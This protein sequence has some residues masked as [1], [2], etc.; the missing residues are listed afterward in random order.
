MAVKSAIEVLKID[1]PKI[2][3]YLEQW[4]RDQLKER[5][6]TKLAV[7]VSG[8]VDSAVVVTLAAR[9]VGPEN[10]TG[11]V[12][13]YDNVDPESIQDAESMIR[14]LRISR[15]F[16]DIAPMVDPYFKTNPTDDR[17][18]KGNKMARERMSVLYDI[19]REATALVIG[20]SN[21]SEICM[22]YGT[23]YG[24]LACAFNPIGNLYKTQ[25]R[26]LAEYLGV[27]RQIIDKIPTAGLWP[28]Q[29]DE[30]ELGITYRELDI[31]LH[32]M[33]DEKY[34]NQKLK[35]MGYQESIINMVKERIA[36]NIFKGRLPA[37]API[38][39]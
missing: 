6:Y 8:G 1:A 10:V 27:E 21:R 17:V 7:G 39:K 28:G 3:G 4:I 5:G 19:S 30:G 23:L 24:D 9:A 14:K 11:V 36:K 26:Q 25:V 31:L 34:S 38:P 16:V 22:G 12:L 13:P 20:T 32:F 18:R 37:I 2:A 33:M 29:T 35:E 15:R